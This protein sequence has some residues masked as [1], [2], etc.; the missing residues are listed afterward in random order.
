[1]DIREQIAAWQER[2]AAFRW[3][4]QTLSI[5]ALLVIA[6]VAM[7]FLQQPFAPAKQDDLFAGRRL[8]PTELQCVEAALGKAELTQYSIQ[9]G[10]IRVPRDQRAKYFAALQDADSLPHSFNG[11]TTLAIEATSMFES[12]RTTQQRMHHALEQE[13]RLAICELSGIEDAFV[14]FDEKTDRSTSLHQKKTLTAVVGVRTSQQADLQTYQVIRDMMLGFKA[15][16]TPADIT[17]T[18]LTERRAIRGSFEESDSYQV[19]S[20]ARQSLERQWK[21]KVEGALAF[22]Q[23]AVVNIRV[24]PNSMSTEAQSV[25]V[26]VGIPSTYLDQLPSSSNPETAISRT[27]QKIQSTLRPLLPDSESPVEELVA[28][29]V[30]NVIDQPL[31]AST[32]VASRV[33]PWFLIAACLTSIALLILLVGGGRKPQAK[34]HSLRVYEADDGATQHNEPTHPPVAE[35]NREAK[36]RAYVADDPSAA[37]K[38]L[39]DFIDRAS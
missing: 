16:L 20:L 30:F 12:P 37:A 32:S 11:P 10:I 3:D 2:L 28:V 1:M 26:S 23:N 7:T 4:A 22:V 25:R 34:P 18:D 13:A 27:R 33:F 8:T 35:S 36:L 17:I 6:V 5:V 24:V 14:F 19:Q 15:D 38:S 31:V 29:N 9:D 21:Q 39:S